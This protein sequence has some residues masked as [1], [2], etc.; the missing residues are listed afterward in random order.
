[1]LS[2]SEDR[3]S[4]TIRAECKSG[5]DH[6]RVLVAPRWFWIAYL[7]STFGG[8]AMGAPL[9]HAWEEAGYAQ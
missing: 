3:R 4:L 2:I 1:M 8:P 9:L 6:V 7:L 5:L